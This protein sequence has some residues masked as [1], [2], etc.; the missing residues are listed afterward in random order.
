MDQGLDP[1]ESVVTRLV[2]AQS[3][4]KKAKKDHEIRLKQ[5]FYSQV[6][7]VFVAHDH[8]AVWDHLNSQLKPDGSSRSLNPVKDKDG[9][10]YYDTDGI[11]AVVKTHYEDLFNWDPQGLSQ[12]YAHWEAMDLGDPLPPLELNEGLYWPEVLVTIRGMNHNTAPGKDGIHINILKA[13]V[14]EECMAEV[15]R[16]SPAFRRPDN[17]R[18]DLPERRL[19]KHPLTKLGKAFHALLTSVWMSGQSPLQW[20]EVWISNLYKGGDPENTSN[21]RRISLIS[22]ALKVL[23]ALMANRLS[24][25]CEKN[26]LLASEQSGFRKGEEAIAQ[27]TALAEVVWRRHLKG[28]PT[29]GLFIDFKKAYDRVYH[30]YLFRLLDHIGV[31]GHFLS[32]LK[33][34]YGETSYRVRMGGQL[35]EAF[36]PI[37]G[38]KQGNPLSPILFILFMNDCLRKSV[39]KGGVRVDAGRVSLGRCPGLMYADDVVI[40][41]GDR[42]DLDSSLDG[43]WNW[44]RTYGMD[45]GREKCGVL[46]WPSSLPRRQRARTALDF[47]SDCSSLLDGDEPRLG[48]LLSELPVDG[49]AVEQDW[50]TEMRTL[51]FEH[52]HY[53][54]STP[55]G[56]IPTV[57]YYKYLGIT[58]DN[59]L[60]DPRKILAGERSMELD[61]AVLQSKK[62]MNVLHSLRPFL[63]DRFCP[64]VIKVALVRNLVYSKMLYRAEMIGFQATHA[65]PLQRVIDLAARWIVGLQKHNTRTDAFTLCLELGLPPVHQE[66][67]A[68]R[69]R[70]AFKLEQHKDG[71]MKTW[72]Q[73]LW[74]H[75]PLTIGNRLTWVSQTKRWISKAQDER[76]KYTRTVTK[77]NEEGTIWLEYDQSRSSPLCP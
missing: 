45:L 48:G 61:F 24:Q 28:K 55:E 8:K 15:Q 34:L 43:I 65:A 33:N 6:T 40:L 71:G 37:R 58:M 7:D 12:N 18:I 10:V 38:S 5:R 74:D 39:T 36:R 46:M 75:P 76:N 26:D 57:T 23:L 56:I 25:V 27:A 20:N 72:L 1:E 17:V 44:G 30:G 60:G 2:R 63:T 3:R 73:T 14:S 22:C 66:L 53:I 21:Y 19:P 50:W 4:F 59:R 52:D 67:C 11:L 47:D 35:S 29:Y 16:L 64:I 77:L 31:R 69:A 42:E 41:N 62:G 49:E 70:L 51:Q 32:L 13:L 68:M 9:E 54:Y